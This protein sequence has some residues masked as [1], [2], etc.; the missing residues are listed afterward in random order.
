MESCTISTRF[1]PL[2]LLYFHLVTVVFQWIYSWNH[3]QR[4]HLVSLMVIS[5]YWFIVN[6]WFYWTLLHAL[7][8]VCVCVCACGCVCVFQSIL[9]TINISL[10]KYHSHMRHHSLN[11]GTFFSSSTV[12]YWTKKRWFWCVWR[13]EKHKF[14][15]CSCW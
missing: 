9:I 4:M 1:S 7:C 6:T 13:N 14:L 12:C 3:G 2:L 11:F 8:L 10:L 5:G 15:L